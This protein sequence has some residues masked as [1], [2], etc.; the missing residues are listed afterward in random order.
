LVLLTKGVS[1]TAKAF[2]TSGKCGKY[3]AI[4]EAPSG[5]RVFSQDFPGGEEI[6][7]DSIWQLGEFLKLVIS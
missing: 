2:L 4:E 1:A 5:A 3:L 7:G 6:A